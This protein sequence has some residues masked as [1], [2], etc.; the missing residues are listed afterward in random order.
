MDFFCQSL[1]LGMKSGVCSKCFKDSKRL[2]DSGI[3]DECIHESRKGN[4]FFELFENIPY[5]N[6]RGGKAFIKS[7]TAR[8]EEKT[9]TKVEENFSDSNSIN[10]QKSP[11]EKSIK[12][13]LY[14]RTIW[15]FLTSFTVFSIYWLYT[16]YF[17]KESFDANSAKDVLLNVFGVPFLFSLYMALGF[18]IESDEVKSVV[19]KIFRG[20]IFIVVACA[21]I[22]IGTLLPTLNQPI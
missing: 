5:S 12:D 1:Y 18:Y 10:E 13:K 21:L 9:P 6:D 3:C 20:I 15:V 2:R 14:D 8:K 22:F 17:H 19:P 16:H 4:K 7:T 11:P